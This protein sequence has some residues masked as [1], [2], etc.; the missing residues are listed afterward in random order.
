[1]YERFCQWLADRLPR[2]VVYFAYIR[3]HAWV[4]T[5]EFS[6]LEPDAV[7]WSMAVKS[8]EKADDLKKKQKRL[9]E[10]AL[11]GGTTE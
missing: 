7:T 9:H 11:F 10:H 5:R 8:W 4:T 1:M 2:R 3:L 6:N